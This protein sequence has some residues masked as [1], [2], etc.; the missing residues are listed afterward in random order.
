MSSEQKPVYLRDTFGR[1]RTR[2]R[3]AML[4]SRAFFVRLCV[5]LF[6]EFGQLFVSFCFFFDGLVPAKKRA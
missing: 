2:F 3:F 6:R 5:D 4:F 1:L